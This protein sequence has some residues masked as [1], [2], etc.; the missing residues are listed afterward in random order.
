MDNKYYEEI[1]GSKLVYSMIVNI[2]GEVI[3]SDRSN[4]CDR[5]ADLKAFYKTIENMVL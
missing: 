4:I 2:W 1:A 5:N 3:R